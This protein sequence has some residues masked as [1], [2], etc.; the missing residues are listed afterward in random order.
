[1]GRFYGNVGFMTT[2]ETAPGV[3]ATQQIVH[4]AYYGD[5]TR[6]HRQLDSS[7]NV[8]SS[9]NINVTIAIVGDEFAFSHLADLRYIE[10]LGSKWTIKSAEPKDRKI[11]LTVGGAYNGG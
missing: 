5:V 2:E 4:H 3:W 11:I 9:P 7:S 6:D 1:M 10:Y 8:N